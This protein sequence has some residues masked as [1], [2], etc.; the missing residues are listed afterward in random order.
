MKRIIAIAL[1]VIMIM[2]MFAGC[3]KDDGKVKIAVVLKKG[4]RK[5]RVERRCSED[6]ELRVLG[7]G[8]GRLRRGCQGA[9]HRSCHSGRTDRG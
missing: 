3:K 4:D 9:G 7:Q 8:Q 6:S 1:A 2:C 5:E